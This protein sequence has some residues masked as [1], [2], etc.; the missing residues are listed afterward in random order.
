VLRIEAWHPDDANRR[1][2]AH[3]VAARRG[4]RDRDPDRDDLSRG[5]RRGMTEA[6]VLRVSGESIARRETCARADDPTSTVDVVTLSGAPRE[7]GRTALFRDDA[8]WYAAL[9]DDADLFLRLR[10]YATDDVDSLGK[11]R[12]ALSRRRE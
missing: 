7:V 4:T 10:G 6:E 9:N 1:V 5:L 3:V 8:L 2:T 11:V 12:K